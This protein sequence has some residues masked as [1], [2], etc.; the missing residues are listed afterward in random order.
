[1]KASDLLVRLRAYLAE[2]EDCDVKLYSEQSAFEEAFDFKHSEVVTD[3]RVVN[4]W[5]LPGESLIVGD[6]ENPG[7]YLVLFY[8]SENVGS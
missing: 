1:M 8:N 7:K 2:H 4:D 5:P 6:T 3:V